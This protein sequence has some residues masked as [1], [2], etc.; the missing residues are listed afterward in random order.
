MNGTTF[1]A[2]VRKQTHT[3]SSTFPDADIVTYAN[4]VKDDIAAT[5]ASEVDEGYFDME[6]T[7]HLEAGIRDYTFPDDILKHVKYVSAKL[8]GTNWLYLTETDMS[9]FDTPMAENSFIKDEYADKKDQFYI[10]GRSLKIL[11][12]DDIID[13]VD[14]LKIVCEIYPED[15]SASNLTASTD[16]SIPSADTTHALPR[17]V[18]K[19]WADRVIVMYKESRDKPLPLTKSEQVLDIALQGI[20][21]KLEKRN[22]VR[23]FQASVPKDDGQD[24]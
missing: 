21:S 12:G 1:A 4:V 20:L 5:I 22:S 2:Y 8:D 13:V 16:L 6:D 19:Y 11:S 14:G 7:R 23:S 9:A 24:Y 17:Q 3:N 18:H 15:I 10:S